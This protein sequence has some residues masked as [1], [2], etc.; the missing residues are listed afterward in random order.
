MSHVSLAAITE[1]RV[2]WH[3]GCLVKHTVQ[4]ENWELRSAW[5]ATRSIAPRACR[6]ADDRFQP[7]SENYQQVSSHAHGLV[8]FVLQICAPAGV[9][10][11]SR[12]SV[13][14]EDRASKDGARRADLSHYQFSD[15]VSQSL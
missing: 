8:R 1:A 4:F 10:T 13:G 9:I 2:V 6:I 14:V 15:F 11:L 12:L 5:C 7:K 3:F